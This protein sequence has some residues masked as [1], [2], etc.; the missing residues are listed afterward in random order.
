MPVDEP[1]EWLSPIVVVHKPSG[2]LRI[3]IDPEQ[4]NRGLKRSIHPVP[5]VEELMPEISQAKV[6]TKCDVKSGFRHIC[7][8]EES[9]K[10]TA[11]ITPF[12]RCRWLRMPFGIAPAPEVFQKS[13]EQALVGLSGVYKIH[14]DIIVVGKDT[15]LRKQRKTTTDD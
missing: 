2:K 5:T 13:L 7:L 6:F 8:E 15:Q 11:F 1:S 3:C 9:S 10:L 14:D 12:G 4:L